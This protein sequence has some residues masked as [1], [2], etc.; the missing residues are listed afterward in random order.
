MS[1]TKSGIAASIYVGFIIKI[2]VV[3]AYLEAFYRQHKR[4]IK[5]QK[6]VKLQLLLYL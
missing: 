2:N 4:N 5:I 3:L 6:Y 1:Q